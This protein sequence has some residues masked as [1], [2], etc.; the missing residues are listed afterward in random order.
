MRAIPLTGCETVK[1][2][3][4]VGRSTG[5]SAET[6]RSCREA[7]DKKH[8]LLTRCRPPSGY[9]YTYPVVLRC[10]LSKEWSQPA[11]LYYDR[12]RVPWGAPS[13]PTQ[14]NLYLWWLGANGIGKVIDLWKSLTRARV[15]SLTDE[16]TT[17]NRSIGSRTSRW[18]IL[19]R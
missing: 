4:A 2:I 6:A 5:G 18:S 7:K 10:A 8:Q 12:T 14:R 1:S 9:G 19:K 17:I 16:S 15:G 11:M 13:L 3:A